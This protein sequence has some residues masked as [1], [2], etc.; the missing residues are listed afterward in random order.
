MTGTFN[1]MRTVLISLV[2]GFAALVAGQTFDADIA[3]IGILQA[4]P[5][6]KEVGLT[7][8]QRATMNRFADAYN[9]E[10]KALGEKAR[11]ADPKNPPKDLDPRASAAYRKLR[12]AVLKELTAAQLKRLR[13]ITLQEVGTPAL[14][15][16]KV[17]KQVGLSEAKRKQIEGIF[18][19]G[20]NKASALERQEMDKALADLRKKKPKTEKEANDLMQEAGKRAD[21]VRTK[22][23]TR[24]R[25]FRRDAESKALSVLDATQ[26]TKWATLQGKPF[27]FPRT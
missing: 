14:A 8:K 15:D 27:K 18:S 10:M 26:K 16:P 6:Q 5:V 24:I 7:E 12:A 3:D 25:A 4:K 21:Q 22:I 1:T 23:E 19:A 17:A 2:L 9:T 13:E 20:A 11:K